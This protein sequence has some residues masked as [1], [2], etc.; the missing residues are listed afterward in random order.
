[1]TTKKVTDQS[2]D[3]DVL[4]A[5][6][7]VVVD[8]WAE[9]CGPCRMIA[10]ALDEIATE[11]G[12]KVTIAKLNIDENANTAIKYGVR[13]I[14]TLILFKNGQPA[15]MKVGAAPKGE[16]SKWIQAAI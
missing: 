13:S 5:E 12:G 4:G 16:L 7:P 14:P 6:T 10:P 9:W 1:M 2:F 11:L 15:A 3:F 8:F